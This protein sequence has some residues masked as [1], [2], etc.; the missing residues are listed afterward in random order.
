[1]IVSIHQPNFF[2]WMGYF[3]K[4]NKSD[5]FV[6]LTSSL[7]SKNDKYLTRTKILNN[8]S[9]LQY[10]SLPLGNK[11]IPI[12]QLIMP[13]DHQWKVKVLNIIKES[14][15]GSN[16][17]DEVY[18]DIE[19]LFMCE[20]EYFSDYSI[21]IIR[22]LISKF[23]IDTELYV[24]TDFNQDFG[25]SNQRNIALCKKAGG[26]IYLSGNGA[27]VYN[28]HKLYRGNSLELI[29]QDYMAPTYTQMSNE[30]VSGLSIIDVLFNCGFEK[31]EK[32]LKQS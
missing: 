18:I 1:M 20:Y 30:F 19:N 11:Q 6:F 2:P 9:K 7:R 3:D 14:Y 24:D 13:A 17:F 27:K 5:K 31:T 10:L 29:Y 22:F 23:N 25:T 16:N 32:L 28:D 12:N 15:R 21:N 4:I 26:D 8:N